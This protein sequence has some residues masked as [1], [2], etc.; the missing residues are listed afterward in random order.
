MNTKELFKRVIDAQEKHTT[1]LDAT[2]KNLSY[3][4][5][6]KNVDLYQPLTIS[7]IDVRNIMNTSTPLSDNPIQTIV[8]AFIDE[9]AVSE[10]RTTVKPYPV[11]GKEPYDSYADMLEQQLS[12]IHERSKRRVLLRSV[13]L[14]LLAHGYYG[15]YFDG[16][17]YYFLTAYELIPGDPNILED[18]AQP[19]LIRKTKVNKATL[20]CAGVDVKSE[21][22]IY[23]NEFSAS[24]DLEMFELYDVYVKHSDQ[25]IGF[26][27]KGTVVY[28][29]GFSHPKNRYPISIANTS[30]LLNSF[31]TVP[32]MSQLVQKLIDYQKANAS[33][34]ESSASIAKPILTYDS[35]AGIDVDALHR[36]LKTGYK[37]IIVGKNR[38]G[39][40]EFKAPGSLPQ[41]AQ[42]LPDKIEE[43]IM[44][45]LGLNKTF[46]GL[47]NVGARERG[48]LARLL[49]TSFRK[50]ASI[51]TVIENVFQEIDTYAIG[52]MADHTITFGKEAGINIEEIFSGPVK[53]LPEEKFVAYSTEDNLEKNAFTLNKW[54]SKLIPTRTALEEMGEETPNKIIEAMNTEEKRKQSFAIELAKK[55][56]T[57]QVKSNLEKI[58]DELKGKLEYRFWLTPISEDKILVKVHVSEAETTAF[59]LS[60]YTSMVR[61]ETYIED[62]P[63]PLNQ[64]DPTVPENQP[65]ISAPPV[66][67]TVPGE[68][69]IVPPAQPEALPIKTEEVITNE[70]VDKSLKK[71]EEETG[72]TST[73]EKPMAVVDIENDGK[74]NPSELEAAISRSKTIYDIDKYKELDGM[75][76]TEPH[77]RWVFTG[78]KLALV[79][80]RSYPE[81]I[82]KPMLFCGSDVYGVIV[83]KKII[84]DFDF[85]AT[86][87][88]HLVT[89]KERKKWWGNSPVYMYI[90]EFYPFKF[91][92][93]YKKTPGQTTFFGKVNITEDN[94]PES[95][96]DNI[97]EQDIKKEDAFEKAVNTKTKT[98]LGGDY[99][100]KTEEANSF[101]KQGS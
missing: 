73:V 33:I 53:Y 38:D 70:P 7:Q 96:K 43:D 6:G 34:K 16:M 63:A 80:G 36:A 88:Y 32:V 98:E 2:Q 50:L 55:T 47:P 30:E 81:Y 54:K 21:Q 76:M 22:S 46:M 71:G 68:P 101:H 41:Y 86:Q 62:V 93:K 79:M 83:L 4:L 3:Y 29:Q 52:Y 84:S 26:T 10:F 15:I 18:Q 99:G 78:R 27:Q 12:L 67:P 60:R 19:F 40:I 20:E 44:K 13:A 91:T 100:K 14:E 69:A 85:K 66:G 35:D 1:F 75:Y 90:F 17:R 61:I 58:S 97:A 64:I 51:S 65:V 94:E 87:K 89:D 57:M 45:S 56:Q 24:D 31:Y 92:M 74:F 5:F 25:N 72:K 48:A 39:G 95:N 11:E 42:Q 37:H 49:K 23:Y 9:L 77:G 82:G 28:E 59:I 8:G